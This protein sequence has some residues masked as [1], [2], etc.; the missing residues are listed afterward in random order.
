MHHLQIYLASASPRRKELLAQIGIKFECLT[1]D[2]PEE[3]KPHEAPQ[4]YADR[5]ALSKAQAGWES[6]E[7]IENCPVLG[8]DTIVVMDNII[9][10]KPIDKD[11]GVRMLQLLSG[12]TH[13]VITSVAVMHGNHIKTACSISR[14]KFRKISAHEAAAYW[15]TKEPTDKAGGYGIQGK[16]AAFVEHIAGSHSGIMGLPLFETANMLKEF[17]INVLEV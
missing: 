13:E 14:V 7:R 9:L 16:A 1:I 4:A 17:G 2:V 12:N 5:L 11:D 15:E 10:E 6:S 3:K 8:A